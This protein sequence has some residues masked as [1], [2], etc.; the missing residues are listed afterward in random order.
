MPRKSKEDQEKHEARE[1]YTDEHGLVRYKDTNAIVGV[2]GRPPGAKNKPNLVK[3]AMKEGMEDTL[4][5]YG[6][7]VLKATAQAAMGTKLKDDKG[8]YIYDEH[9]N[10][11]YV[12]GD[13]A[14]KKML[15]DRIAPVTEINKTGNGDKFTINISVTGMEARIDQIDGEPVDAEFEEVE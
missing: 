2:G 6:I 1:K 8:K 4:L 7:D 3:M 10:H 5:Q 13:N 11:M 12:N 14:C 15:L 9:G